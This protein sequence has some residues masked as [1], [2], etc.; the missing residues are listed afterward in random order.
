[1]LLSLRC[2]RELV[3]KQITVA[4]AAGACFKTYLKVRVVGL[5]IGWVLADLAIGVVVGGMVCLLL[6]GT[7]QKFH[8][9]EEQALMKS[10]QLR[11]R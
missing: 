7:H 9:T 3:V 5:Q 2:F 1:M 10:T 8:F 6:E 4:A 11:L